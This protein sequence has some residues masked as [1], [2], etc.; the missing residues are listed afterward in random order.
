MTYTSFNFTSDI[1][2]DN[3]GYDDTPATDVHWLLTHHKD[4]P[5]NKR[6]NINI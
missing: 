1:I 3:Q 5:I 2:S 4:M 6:Q